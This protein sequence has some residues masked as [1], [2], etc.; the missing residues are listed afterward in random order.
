MQGAEAGEKVL[1]QFDRYPI[2]L[3]LADRAVTHEPAK[4]NGGF[5]IAYAHCFAAALILGINAPVVTDDPDFRRMKEK[6]AIG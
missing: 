6:V 5:R 4:L 3:I 1:Q 2:Q